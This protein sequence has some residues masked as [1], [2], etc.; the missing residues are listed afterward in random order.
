MTYQSVYKQD[1]ETSYIFSDVCETQT[2]V[3]KRSSGISKRILVLLLT[4]A[5]LQACTNSVY[6]AFHQVGKGRG[7]GRDGGW[8]AKRRVL[9]MSQAGTCRDSTWVGIFRMQLIHNNPY[10]IVDYIL[11]RHHKALI[12]LSVY[13]HGISEYSFLVN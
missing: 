12:Y 7:R 2:P 4:Y 10:P 8:G 6:Q 5:A 11:P 3:S 9:G 1:K 13:I